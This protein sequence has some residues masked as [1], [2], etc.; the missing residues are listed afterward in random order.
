MEVESGYNRTTF[1]DDVEDEASEFGHS[2]FAKTDV[3][4][5]FADSSSEEEEEADDDK[6]SEEMKSDG[7]GGIVL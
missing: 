7:I 3:S 4:L 5:S 1:I 6:S 2:N